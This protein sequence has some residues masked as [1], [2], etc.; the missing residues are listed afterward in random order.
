MDEP[1]STDAMD[2]WLESEPVVL[3]IVNA[4]V[5]RRHID[6]E[7]WLQDA[8]EFAWVQAV[9]FNPDHPSGAPWRAV[10]IQRVQW[11]ILWRRPIRKHN[12]ALWPIDHIDLLPLTTQMPITAIETRVAIER[13]LPTMSRDAR[14]YWRHIQGERGNLSNRQQA[15]M[16]EWAAVLS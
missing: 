9:K 13:A 1:M 5:G 15:A 12:R 11:F 4:M 10:L 6:Y 8:R 7:D 14:E 2:R 3:N 16:N